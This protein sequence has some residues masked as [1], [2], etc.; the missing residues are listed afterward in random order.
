MPRRTV[1]AKEASDFP[2]FSSNITN[3]TPPSSTGEVTASDSKKRR[4]RKPKGGK[5]I[6]DIVH[7]SNS[8]TDES[9]NVILHLRCSLA[10]LTSNNRS[11][12]PEGTNETNLIETTVDK[13]GIT[14]DLTYA[15]LQS[16]QPKTSFVVQDNTN[17][18]SSLQ[19]KHDDDALLWRKIK[20]LGSLLHENNISDKQSACFWCTCEFDSPPIFIP[21]SELGGQYSVYGCFCSPECGVAYLMDQKI[22]SS[23]KFERYSLMNHLYCPTFGYTKNIKPAPDPHYTLDKFFGNLSIQEYRRLLKSERLLMVV[24]KPLTRVLPELH[25]DNTDFGSTA[26]TTTT[27]G[28]SDMYRLKRRTTQPDKKTVVNNT[29]G[30]GY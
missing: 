29:F 14:G 4:G 25:Q 28:S 30:C 2:S 1:A 20:Q 9:P 23:S 21:S 12:S 13:V 8:T 5:V 22:D 26:G 24:D 6:K 3:A 16:H 18:E 27:S 10:D 17:Q 15:F 11:L 7:S 19:C